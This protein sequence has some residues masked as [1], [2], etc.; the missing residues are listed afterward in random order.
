MSGVKLRSDQFLYPEM[1]KMAKM[2]PNNLY[3][4][5]LYKIVK[6]VLTKKVYQQLTTVS[7]IKVWSDLLKSKIDKSLNL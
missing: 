4:W 7:I 1:P 6:F 3:G 2:L 5:A